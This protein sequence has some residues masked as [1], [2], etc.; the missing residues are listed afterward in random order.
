M[1]TWKSF[2]KREEK[3]VKILAKDRN[4][5]QVSQFY[6]KKQEE[7]ESKEKTPFILAFSVIIV[8]EILSGFARG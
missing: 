5:V 4:V 2:N 7:Q 8:R 6:I 3:S 1:K